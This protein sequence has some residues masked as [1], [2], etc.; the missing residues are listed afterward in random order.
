MSDGKS[1]QALLLG[2]TERHEDHKFQAC[3]GYL[4]RPSQKKRQNR[5]LRLDLS[6]E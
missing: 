3:L 6:V 2:K 5:G 1:L 4:V